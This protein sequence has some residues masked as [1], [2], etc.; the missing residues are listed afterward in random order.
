MAKLN[1]VEAI[2]LALKEEMSRDDRI[3]L[4]GEDVG[5]LGGVFR[6]TDGLQARYGPERV[7]DTPL[8]EAA[9]IGTSIGLALG[10]FKPVPE[11][12]FMGFLPAA[13]DQ[14]ICHVSRYRN[15]SR[16]RYALPMVIRMPYGAGIHAP[17][18]HSES[19]EAILAHLPGLKVVI[20]ATPYDAKGLLLAALRDP[21]PVVFLEPKRLYRAIREEVPEGDYTVPLG[22]AKVMREGDAVTVVAWGAMGREAMRAAELVAEEGIEAE[23]IDLRTIAPLD[24]ETIVASIRKTGRGVIV[25]EACR[26]GG[27]AAEIMA[28]IQEKAFLSL[29]APLERVTGFDTIVPLLRLEDYY[30]PDADRISRAIRKVVHF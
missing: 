26:T 20:P 21:D 7:V 12:Q 8:A 1:M 6:V 9:I 27:L 16:G 15:R 13:L 25:H 24:D 14:I 4:L 28:R 17:E 11:I 2:N 3:I 29:A 23:V 19:N 18:H 5:R 22:T 30:L 10:G